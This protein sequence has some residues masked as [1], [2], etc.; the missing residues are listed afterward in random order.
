MAWRAVVGIARFEHCVM[1]GIAEHDLGAVDHAPSAGTGNGRR[2]PRNRAQGHGPP[3]AASPRGPPND[4]AA[5]DLGLIECDRC[6]C[7]PCR[8]HWVHIRIWCHS[9]R[10]EIPSH[11]VSSDRTS[12]RCA[13]RWVR[14][15]AVDAEVPVRTSAAR[16]RQSRCRLIRRIESRMRAVMPYAHVQRRSRRAWR[17]RPVQKQSSAVG[18]GHRA[19]R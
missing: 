4:V 18:G 15:G 9:P 6:F 13:T 7:L 1:V 17:S 14:S 19:R 5:F 3:G 10:R 16:W 8:G 2:R 12:I 11:A